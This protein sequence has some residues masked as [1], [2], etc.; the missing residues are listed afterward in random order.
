MKWDAAISWACDAFDHA[1]CCCWCSWCRDPSEG[2]ARLRALAE[3]DSSCGDCGYR[4]DP[5]FGPSACRDMRRRLAF[6][7]SASRSSAV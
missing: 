3:L 5:A 6:C 4:E 1:A 7:R 2:Y